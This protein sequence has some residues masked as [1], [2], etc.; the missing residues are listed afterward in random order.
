MSDYKERLAVIDCCGQ[1]FSKI[2]CYWLDDPAN[3]QKVTLEID[4]GTIWNVTVCNYFPAGHPSG[5]RKIPME[6]VFLESSDENLFLLLCYL[7]GKSDPADR[8]SEEE[9]AAKELF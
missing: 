4:P 2:I 9:W 7:C 5:P 8:W 3:A 1:R 6:V